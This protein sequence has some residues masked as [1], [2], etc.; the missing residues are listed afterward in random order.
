M[1]STPSTSESLE[2][3]FS[4]GSTTT[5]YERSRGSRSYML[6]PDALQREPSVTS[7]ASERSVLVPKE[8]T[9]EEVPLR[10]FVV[11]LMIAILSHGI[12]GMP[13]GAFRFVYVRSFCKSMYLFAAF[14]RGK[15]L[16]S[17]ILTERHVDCERV[18]RACVNSTPLLH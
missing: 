4:R 15:F 9:I 12:A 10:T 1:L 18:E 7:T 5:R 14:S 8:D 17:C 2:L 6:A 3:E 11:A 13:S 16:L